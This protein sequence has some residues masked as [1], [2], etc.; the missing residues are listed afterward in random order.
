MNT[1][2]LFTILGSNVVVAVFSYFSGKRKTDADTDNSILKNLEI[3]INIYQEI[4]SD[5]KIEIQNLNVKIQDLEEKIDEL[6]EE[7]KKLKKL[8]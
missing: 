6:H 4:I 7:N 8:I 1:E 2:T 3:S 5:L